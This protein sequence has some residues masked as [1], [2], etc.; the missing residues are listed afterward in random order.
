MM[1]VRT[2]ITTIGTKG[3][4]LQEIGIHY[5]EINVRANTFFPAGFDKTVLFSRGN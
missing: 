2:T 4:H 3:D 1:T 5:R